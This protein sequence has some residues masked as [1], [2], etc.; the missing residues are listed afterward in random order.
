[1]VINDLTWIQQNIFA[2][3]VSLSSLHISLK[4]EHL[5][6]D[7]V[8][9]SNSSLFSNCTIY[10]LQLI[11]NFNTNTITNNVSIEHDK[12]FETAVI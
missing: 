3:D 7:L 10:I 4:V 12:F 6:V 8:A 11:Q 2:A 1:M 9:R 5:C